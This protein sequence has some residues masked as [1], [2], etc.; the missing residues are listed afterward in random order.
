MPFSPPERRWFSLC[1]Y[2]LAVI[3]Y[4]DLHYYLRKIFKLRDTCFFH[5]RTEESKIMEI[6]AGSWEAYP[7]YFTSAHL[8]SAR[9]LMKIIQDTWLVWMAGVLL[10]KSSEI[11]YL[12]TISLGSE[13][14]TRCS[15]SNFN[16]RKFRRD[17]LLGINKLAYASPKFKEVLKMTTSSFH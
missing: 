16:V 1:L 4:I 3:V 14:F 5:S 17:T 8:E 6:L 11:L 12:H 7:W 13:M 9:S 15:W 10:L 2:K